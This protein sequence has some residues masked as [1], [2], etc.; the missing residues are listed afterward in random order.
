MVHEHKYLGIK[1]Q[2]E[3]KK[4]L[5]G[6]DDSEYP[7]HSGCSYTR[8]YFPDAFDQGE[9][10]SKFAN[11]LF[12][13]FKELRQEYNLPQKFDIPMQYL[14]STVEYVFKQYGSKGEGVNWPTMEQWKSAVKESGYLES[15]VLMDVIGDSVG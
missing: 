2:S 3:I 9:R 7:D 10:I 11:E 8:F 14:A 15:E 13:M 4:C 12:A 5:N 6:Y 1:N